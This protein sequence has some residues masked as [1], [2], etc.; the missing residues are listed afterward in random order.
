MRHSV[1][2]RLYACVE[3]ELA[4]F[5]RGF[6]DVVPAAL[7]TELD[8]RE[9]EMLVCGLPEIDVDDWRSNTTYRGCDGSEQAVQWFWEVSGGRPHALRHQGTCC[10]RTPDVE[11]VVGPLADCGGPDQLRAR[12]ATPVCHRIVASATRRLLW[13][14]GAVRV[15][16][17]V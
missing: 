4:M 13:A 2:Y 5:L 14:P 12:A 9:L 1:R 8:V 10:R 11:C 3:R 16:C 7:L 15:L 6:Y 17:T